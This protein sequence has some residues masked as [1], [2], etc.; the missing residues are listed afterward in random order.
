AE[1][2]GLSLAGK[3]GAEGVQVQIALTAYQ[4]PASASA[5]V[6]RSRPPAQ[7]QGVDVQKTM[8]L[9]HLDRL[10]AESIHIM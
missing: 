7:P 1:P 10:E 6:G 4:V 2:P 3:P 5:T 8:G 9:S